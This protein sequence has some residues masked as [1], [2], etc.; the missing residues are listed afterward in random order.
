MRSSLY[1][2]RSVSRSGIVL[3]V[4]GLLPLA[5]G[6]AQDPYEQADQTWISISGEV[7]TAGRD[8]FVLDY[9]E[10]RIVVDIADGSR[11]AAGYV[12][13]NGDRVTVTGIVDDDLFETTTIDASSVYIQHLDTYFRAQPILDDSPMIAVTT[14]VV[15]AETVLQGTVTRVGAQQFTIDTGE[16]QVSIQVDEMRNDPLDE[17]GYQQVEEG[18]L[19]SVT[20]T[21][22]ADFLE[23]RVIKARSVT[24]IRS[25]AG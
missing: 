7:E 10:G 20:G 8:F 19:V 22:K 12:L 11:D 17:E 24:T 21:V 3:V 18:D 1:L 16:R 14:P 4:L 6:L 9:G 25:G 5:A 13:E 23:G 15:I 2:K